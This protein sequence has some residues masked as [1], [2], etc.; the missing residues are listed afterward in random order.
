[1]VMV[2]LESLNTARRSALL[3]LW[4]SG[5]PLVHQSSHLMRPLS[6]DM[7]TGLYTHSM[8]SS[9]TAINIGATSSSS[10]PNPVTISFVFGRLTVNLKRFRHI[11]VSQYSLLC[12]YSGCYKESSII[13]K[14][15]IQSAGLV[16]NLLWTF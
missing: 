16:G 10:T 3:G 15:H 5:S 6:Q 8:S 2:R 4:L 13:S 1:M 14:W 9:C 7:E 11:D 12:T